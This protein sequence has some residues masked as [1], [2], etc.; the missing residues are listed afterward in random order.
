M[1][2]FD[3]P[4]NLDD[5]K[6]EGRAHWHAHMAGT[7]AVQRALLAC[8]LR[9]TYPEAT[10]ANFAYVDPRQTEVPA[11]AVPKGQPWGGFP[12]YLLEVVA[13]NDQQEAWRLADEP[14]PRGDFRT[15]DVN[16]EV[17]RE[18]RVQQDEYLE[19]Y[20]DTDEHGIWRVSLTCEGPEYW[21]QLAAADF[22][23]V[24]RTYEKLL[25]RDIPEDELKFPNDVFIGPPE[26]G[27]R[28]YR[29]GS[30]N[31]FNRW[32]TSDGAIHLTQV[33]NTLGAEINLASRATVP[34][35]DASEQPVRDRL[36]LICC[37]GFGDPNR[38]SDPSIG[39][40]A[41]QAADSGQVLTL[42]NPIGLYISEF[43][44]SGI[45]LPEGA[46]VPGDVPPAQWWE[47]T[48]GER[49]SPDGQARML[50]VEYEVP[51]GATVPTPDGGRRPLR[52]ADLDIG[53]LPATHGGALAELVTMHLF[54]TA[55]DAPA[56][57]ERLALNC[58][59][60][61][62][63]T[64]RGRLA[65][66]AATNGAVFPHLLDPERRALRCGE[67]DEERISDEVYRATYDVA[68][69]E[70][71]EALGVD[72]RLDEVVAFGAEEPALGPALLSGYVAASRV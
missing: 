27:R 61:C 48:R 68:L 59:T 72:L 18:A 8:E 51:E 54:V 39:A 62:C 9:R 29:A 43:D 65:P 28:R 23:T 52:L 47:C 44:T 16:G 34:R 46:E 2:L 36:E 53:G 6:A 22:A 10:E 21:E 20:A 5:L 32:N 66:C 64:A 41:N 40:T 24:H 38:D 7:T 50:R 30:Y 58:E 26:R 69:R 33:N 1:Y 3:P 49:R 57:G 60:T 63:R 25:R 17:P 4:A 11:S 67:A 31:P 70:A 35:R 56:A 19:W 14:G 45:G 55:W 13:Q 12:R 71:A 42:T 15:F 37:A